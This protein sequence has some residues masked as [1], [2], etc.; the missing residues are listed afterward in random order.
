MCDSSAGTYFFNDKTKRVIKE[1]MA[2]LWEQFTPPYVQKLEI[3]CWTKKA[4]TQREVQL[5]L[6]RCSS[7]P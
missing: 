2:I 4:V 5:P 7:P 6:H 1:A 3:A